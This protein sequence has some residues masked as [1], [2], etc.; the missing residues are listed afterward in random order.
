MNLATI[1]QQLRAQFEGL[2]GRHPALWPTLPRLLCPAG[3][4]LLVIGLG[5]YLIWVPQWEA[6]ENGTAT[7][8]KLRSAFEQKVAQ[9]Q[10]LDALRQQKVEVEAEIARQQQQLPSKA[11]M[12]A[13][14]AEISQVGVLH[15]LQIELFKPGQLKMGEHYAELPIEIRLTGSYHAFAAFVSD[16][17][18]MSRIVTLDRIMISQQREGALSFD[19]VVH[20]FRY[21]DP[22]EAQRKQQ[23]PVER[24]RPEQR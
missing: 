16:I 5:G 6:L 8:L 10:H 18:N 3:V 9:A 23:R 11:E 12:D 2:E 24:K 13:L 17:A 22:A 20:A 21:L 7:E 4:A 14:L 19:A 1:V 15:G